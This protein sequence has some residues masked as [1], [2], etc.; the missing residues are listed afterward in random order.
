MKSFSTIADAVQAI[1]EGKLII[2]VDDLHRENEGDFVCSAQHIT[3]TLVNHMITDGK[4]LV[5]VPLSVEKANQLGLE[6]MVKDNT[7]TYRTAFTLSVDALSTTTGISAYERAITIN[8]LSH[9]SSQSKDFKKPGHIFPL[10]GKKGGVLERPG[11]TEASLELMKLAG[12]ESAAVICEILNPDGTMARREDLLT[13]A[14]KH[15]MIII[16]IA[17]LI[18]YIKEHPYA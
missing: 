18:H 7:D 4:G 17:Q 8:L 3:P 1:K 14:S 11:H 13:Y 10:I 16:E 15:R 5:C 12:L 6:P 2:L 9:P